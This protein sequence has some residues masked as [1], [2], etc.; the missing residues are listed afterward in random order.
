MQ[1]K[2][3]LT[4]AV[5]TILA[6]S[7]PPAAAGTD[8]SEAPSSDASTAFSMAA[9]VTLA[10]TYLWHGIDYSD[11]HPVIQPEMVLGYDSFSATVWLNGDLHDGLVTEADLYLSYTRPIRPLSLT[12][13]YAYFSYPHREGWDPSQEVFMT[14]ALATRFHPSLSLHHDYQTGKGLYAE[15]GGSGGFEHPLG[16]LTVGANLYYH[17]SYYQLTG[18]PAIEIQ[19]G[20]SFGVG[21]VTLSLSVTYFLTWDNGDFTG[22]NAVDDA[23]V[24]SLNIARSF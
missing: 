4:L 7:F 13:G 24:Y 18:F 5:I 14:V 3:S 12:L 15:L 2:I 8:L 11:G 21:P 9:D 16:N 17:H 1:I 19:G 20:N 23:W 10:S 6:A 22:G